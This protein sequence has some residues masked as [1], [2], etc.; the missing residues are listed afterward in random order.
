M[1]LRRFMACVV[2]IVAVSTVGCGD[3]QHFPSR[4]V[5]LVCPWSAGGGTDRVSRQMAVQLERELGMPVNVVNATGGGGV[6]GHTRGAMARADGY[7]V[8]MATVELNML[9]WRG[10][11]PVTAESFEPLAML[12]EDSAAVFVMHDSEWNS[13]HDLEETIRS[14]QQPLR[15][16]GT[17]NGGI[18]HLAMTGWLSERQVPLNSVTWISINGSAPS[19]QELIAGGIEFVCCSIPEAQSLL[20]AGEIRCLGV[21]SRRRCDAAPEVPTFAE[22]GIHWSMGGWRG[23]MYP[24]DVPRERV[25]RMREAILNVAHSEEFQTFMDSAGFQ[26]IIADGDDFR[27]FLK[28]SD[29]EF[30][31]ILN[32]PDVRQEH[33]APFSRYFLPIVL[34]VCGAGAGL[35]GTFRN[36]RSADDEKRGAA[37]AVARDPAAYLRI[38][39]FVPAIAAYIALCEISGYVIASAVLLL[40]LL[41]LLKVRLLTSLTIAAVTV[42]ALYQ[43]F[44]KVLGVPLPWGW[45]GW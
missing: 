20:D 5:T 10:L 25:T 38:A 40:V 2:L 28:E 29:A 37:A 14:T 13:I 26:R 15:A 4:P 8:T 11:C 30:G 16:S 17:A 9:H 44:V 33:K 12:N 39:G 22:Q 19:L 27:T 31:V 43:L 35:L 42:P 7:T 18:W 3:G 32:R 24:R 45:L 41:L 21:M 6:T 36:R 34:A 23:L 1:S